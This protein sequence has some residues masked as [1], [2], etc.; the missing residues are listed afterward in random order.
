[1]VTPT[2]LAPAPTPLA[3]A[4]TPLALPPTACTPPPTALAAS[5]RDGK[6]AVQLILER[7][8]A[9]PAEAESL[10]IVQK[11][12]DALALATLTAADNTQEKKRANAPLSTQE[13]NRTANRIL[14]AVARIEG[15]GRMEFADDEAKREGF[16]ALGAGPQ[17]RRKSP[18]T[19]EAAPAMGG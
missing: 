16:E 18:A 13:R 8:K 5:L 15:A 10:G 9:N 7:A 2:P 11:D 6:V 14:A 19:T 4:P 3:E 12:L 1:L 17:A